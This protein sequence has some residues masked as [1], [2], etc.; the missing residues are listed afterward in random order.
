M[1]MDEDELDTI[2]RK[3]LAELQQYQT[4][5]QAE[6]QYR[7]QQQAQRQLILRQI[8]TPE[9]RERLGRIGLAYPEPKGNIHNPLLSLPPSGRAQRLIRRPSLRPIL[10]RG[11][12]RKPAL[13]I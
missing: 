8:L 13:K 4:Q 1:S 2:R 9:A 5:A 6:A 11:A 3:K 10:A 7:D 12:S